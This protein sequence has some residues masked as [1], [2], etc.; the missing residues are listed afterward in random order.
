MRKFPSSHLKLGNTLELQPLS[1]HSKRAYLSR[2]N[3]LLGFLCSFDEDYR[4]LFK[5]ETERDYILKDYKQFLKQK[6]KASPNAVNAALAATDHS[7]QFLGLPKAK[8]KRE[9][10]PAEAPMALTKAQQKKAHPG[11][12]MCQ[13]SKRPGGRH[14]RSLY[15][16]SYIRVRRPEPGQCLRPGTQKPD[17]YPQ[18]QRRP[19]PRSAFK[20]RSL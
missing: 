19:L 12:R 6:H 10:I 11:S 5:D 3:R 17:S 18:Q 9:H 16:N 2:L 4:D 8:V 14:P 13:A 1:D 15:G 20:R 7:Y